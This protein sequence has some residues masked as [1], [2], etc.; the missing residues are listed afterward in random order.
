MVGGIA[1]LIAM[2]DG[3]HRRVPFLRRQEADRTAG[4]SRTPG[5]WVPVGPAVDLP[6]S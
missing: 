6:V 1:V 2:C 3:H 4:N 5:G